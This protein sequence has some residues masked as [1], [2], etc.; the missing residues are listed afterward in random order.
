MDEQT[1]ETW[2]DET[3][4]GWDAAERQVGNYQERKEGRQK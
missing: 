2:E 3:V 4:S 1:A